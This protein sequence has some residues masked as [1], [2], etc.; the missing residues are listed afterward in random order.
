MS[1]QLLSYVWLWSHRVQHTRPPCPSPT[2]RVYSNSCPLSQWWHPT[3]SS[4]VA[5]FSSHLQSFPASGSPMSQFF[6]SGGQSIGV[7]A[8]ASVLSMNIEDWFS[9]GWTGWISLQSKGLL[10]S[11]QRQSSKASVLWRSAFFI[12][13]FSYPYMT[14]G[15]T[16]ALTI[17]IFVSI[18]AW[19]CISIDHGYLL[20]WTRK[21]PLNSIA[22]FVS[23]ALLQCLPGSRYEPS[24]WSLC[25]QLPSFQ[26][27][28]YMSTWGHVMSVWLCHNSSAAFFCP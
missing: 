15:K 20:Y 3:I 23:W 26:A 2:P 22:I 24:N 14:T 11:L 18:L 16:I 5:P 13:Q 10:K 1:V 17:W 7:S 28:L 6:T 21:S 19:T 12:V 8:S 9:L 25:L 4:S 27:K